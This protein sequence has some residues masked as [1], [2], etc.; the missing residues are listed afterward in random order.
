MDRYINMC[1]CI[2]KIPFT[3][4]QFNSF[5]RQYHF[6]LTMRNNMGNISLNKLEDLMIR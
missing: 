2:Q 6:N 5:S 4:V 3:I 1:L